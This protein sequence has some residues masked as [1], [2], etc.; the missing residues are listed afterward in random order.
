MTCVS[1]IPALTGAFATTHAHAHA[2]KSKDIPSFPRTHQSN[3]S[4]PRDKASAVLSWSL[5]T[6]FKSKY[7]VLLL[8]VKS[9]GRSHANQNTSAVSTY[10]SYCVSKKE[11]EYERERERKRKPRD[12][13]LF[14]FLF[15]SFELRA[16]SLCSRELSLHLISL[17]WLSSKLKQHYKKYKT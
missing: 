8:C 7:A 15:A 6:Q 4:Q 1:D 16:Q 17:S 14:L 5:W 11:K 2:H 12:N 9:I 13:F 3:S 10:G